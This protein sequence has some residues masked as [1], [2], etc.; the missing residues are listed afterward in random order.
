MLSSIYH[1]PLPYFYEYVF[2][3]FQYLTKKNISTMSKDRTNFTT[4]DLV[5]DIWESLDLPKEA[6][7]SLHLTG[8]GL[9]LPSSFKIGLLAQ[10]TI[11]LSALA[12]SLVHA[13]RNGVTKPPKITVPLKHA[14]AEFKSER[15]YL[16]NGQRD[17]DTK[18][19][20]GGL[21]ETSDGWVRVHDSFP[22]HRIGAF[23]LLGL[24]ED[25]KRSKV[26]ATIKEWKALDIETTAFKNNIVIAALRSFEEWDELPQAK[27]LPE[28][29]IRITKIGN[30][31][32]SPERKLDRGNHKCLSRLRVLE[33]SRVIAA[34]VAGRTLSAYGADVLWVTSPNLP[35]LPLLDI[36]LSRGKRSI[37]LDLNQTPDK[38]RCLALVKEANIIIQSYR[39]NSF[40]NLGLSPQALI[41]ENPNLIIAN[42]SAYGPTGPWSDKRGFDSMIQTCTGLNTAEANNFGNGSPA[43]V[44]PCQALD[45]ASGYFLST[46]IL[47]ALYTQLT[48]GGGAYQVDVSLAGTEKYL[49][50]LG[51]Y[52]GRSGFECD[53]IVEQGDVEEFCETRE[54]AFGELKALRHSASIEEV[55]VGW[56]FMPERLGSGEAIWNEACES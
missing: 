4:S 55:D 16:L 34:P 41:K 24:N 2:Y 38:E 30:A 40:A 43:R 14:C 46:G 29:P 13:T 7:N 12:A 32:T 28:Y 6:L 19:A 26:A 53:D 52:E 23:K 50:S 54:C 22:N 56:D 27:A 25:T 42:L 45:H 20:V 11:S 18:S 10:A 51:Q 15:L 17:P 37:Q 21:F 8:T 47:A 33:F 3:R 31:T 36:D 1:T 49:R 48:E 35:D 44:L 9:G 5:A 39:P